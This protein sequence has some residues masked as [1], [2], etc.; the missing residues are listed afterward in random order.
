M[1]IPSRDDLAALI[2]DKYGGD[3]GADIAGDVARL[4]AGEPLAYVIGWVPFLGLHVDLGSRPLIPRAETEYWTEV[5]I[6]HLAKRPQVTL[7]DLCAGSGA[8]GLS[9]LKHVPGAHVSFGEL[10]LPHAELIRKNI[11]MNGLDA[12]RALV[13]RGNL[14]VP[15][16]GER[17]DVIAT[18]PPYIPAGREL[19]GSVIG[20]EPPVALF[21]GA[22]GIDLIDRIAREAAHHLNPGGELWMECDIDNIETARE[23]VLTGGAARADIRT[24]QYG[25]PRT[26]V[27]YY[28]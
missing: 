25:R 6:T 11:E 12:A 10:E 13:R 23:L 8:I 7:L 22:E 17:F 9:V 3:A 2:R 1:S 14:F 27:G 19:D 26:L 20:Y 16:S 15:F 4:S 24:D 28:A 18:N 21:A 5:L